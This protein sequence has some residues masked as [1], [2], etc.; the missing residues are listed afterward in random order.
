MLLEGVILRLSV[1]ALL[2][3][4][5]LVPAR[6]SAEVYELR[7]YT[8]N[9][10]K[11]DNLNARFRDHTV[12]LFEKHGIESVGYW[13]PADDPKSKNTLI[14]V[15]K[16]KSRDAAKASWRAFLADPEWKKVAR[17][18]QRD[19]RIL[20]KAPESVFM[21]AADY[22]PKFSNDR[23]SGDAVFELRIYRTNKGKLKN[24]DARFR[25]HTIR[26]FNRFGIQSVAYWHPVDEPD[27]KDTLIYVIRHDSRDAAKKSWK[28]FGADKEWKRVAKESQEDGRFLR[29]RPESIYM[30]ATDYSAIR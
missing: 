6:A 13:V 7:T 23:K 12:R 4:L 24:L 29:E 28:S 17:E 22:S 26:I 2:A 19:G 20:A 18:S 27:S 5:F 8:T 16:H 30:K 3:G 11:L 15:V 10:G 1:L 25:D 9:E 14:Y 21:N